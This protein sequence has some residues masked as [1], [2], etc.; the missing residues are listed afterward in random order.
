AAM[1]SISKALA[2][3]YGPK[4]RVNSVCPGPIWTPFWWKPG[5]FLETIEEAYGKKGEDAVAALVEDRGIP[6][7]RFGQPDEV[8]QAVVFLASP[9]A[10]FITGAA[11]GVDGGTV[12]SPLFTSEG[13][14]AASPHVIAD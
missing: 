5:G 4:V 10:S 7:G 14:R 13:I 12:R 6:L 1:L 11:L 3:A 8:A 2:L 9:A